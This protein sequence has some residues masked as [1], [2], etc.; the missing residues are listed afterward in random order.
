MVEA[1]SVVPGVLGARSICCPDDRGLLVETSKYLECQTCR[2]R[3]PIFGGVPSF[4]SGD[5]GER[6]F[7]EEWHREQVRQRRNGALQQAVRRIVKPVRY[8]ASKRERLFRKTF[9]GK[10]QSPVLDIACG[11]GHSF[12]CELGPVTGVDLSLES[13]LA[14]KQQGWY[15]GLAHADARRL[16]FPDSV[17]EYVVSADFVGHVRA[18][19]KD[20]VIAEMRRVLAPG[21]IIAHVIET[22]STNACF[23]FAH[24]FPDL[25]QRYFVE[26]I[27]G[28]FGLEMPGEAIRRLEKHGFQILEVRKMWGPVWERESMFVSLETSMSSTTGSYGPGSLHADY[29]HRILRPGYRRMRFWESSV[30]SWTMFNR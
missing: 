16:P 15:E 9:R 10:R 12:F 11:T 21:G 28:H 30:P 14:L 3:W 24:R 29:C 4:I 2:C 6:L 7:Y 20:E 5:T 18:P 25:F 26:E 22:D 27:G 8:F 13:L 1:V 23:R 17:F 19:A